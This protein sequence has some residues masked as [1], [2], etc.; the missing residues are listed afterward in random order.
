MVAEMEL[1]G[2]TNITPLYFCLWGWI[3]SEYYQIKVDTADE[4]LLAFWMPLAA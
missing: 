2:S 1:F 3:K 4:L